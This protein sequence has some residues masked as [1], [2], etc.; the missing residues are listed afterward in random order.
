M[1]SLKSFQI[2]NIEPRQILTGF[3]K[4]NSKQSTKDN[5]KYSIVS[6]VMQLAKKVYVIII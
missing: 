5:S 3:I 2:A 1:P 4:R 6:L